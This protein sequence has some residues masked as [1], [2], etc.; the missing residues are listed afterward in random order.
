[1][2]PD[3]RKA[4]EYKAAVFAML[5]K[6]N[7]REMLSEINADANSKLFEE[8]VDQWK[9]AAI[10]FPGMTFEQ[11]LEIAKKRERKQTNPGKRGPAPSLM[12]RL[13]KPIAKAARDVD[14]IREYWLATPEGSAGGD[15]PI[16]HIDLAAEWH[17]HASHDLGER[18]RRGKSR[19]PHKLTDRP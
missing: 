17:D 13:D 10:A 14:R 6:I 8:L 9:H 12:S 16:P 11:F 5:E 3:Q 7:E 1:M 19:N 2:T 15:P 18:V 4:V